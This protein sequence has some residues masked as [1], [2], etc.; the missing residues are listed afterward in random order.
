MINV[1][2][3]VALVLLGIVL[4][5]VV[6]LLTRR[7]VLDVAPLEIRLDALGKDQER[8]ERTV[9]DEISRGREEAAQHAKNLREEVGTGLRSANDSLV[10][11]LKDIS[12][13]QQ[14]QLSAFGAE[15]ADMKETS[16]TN[17]GHL[18]DDIASGF[19]E[20]NEAALRQMT[21][22][23]N[24][25]RG[26][27]TAMTSTLE[28]RLK[29]L[30]DDH[31]GRVDKISAEITGNAKQAREETVGTLLGFN[32][33][34]VRSIG[35][36]GAAQERELKELAV[37]FQSLIVSNE[38]KLDAIRG[39]VEEKLGLIQTDNA[40]RLDEMRRT[41][42]EKLQATLERRL[43]ES[44]RLV[45]E[46]LEQ[47]HRGL[48][49]MQTLA[50][51]VGDLKRVLTNVKARGSWGEVQLGNL[52]DEILAPEQF[53]KNVATKAS[54]GE[55]VDYAIK[56]PRTG[57]DDEYVWLP[58][59]AKFPVEDYQRLVDAAD[60]A[61]AAGVDL[62]AKQ[63]EMRIRACAQNIC[64][65]Y[66]NPPNTTDFGIM[67]LPTEGLYAEAVRRV[68]L[69]EALQREYRVV[70]AGPTTLAALLNSLQMGFR[71]LAI[72]KRSSEVWS[73]LGAVKTEFG[74]FGDVLTS[75]QKKLAEASATIDKAGVRTRAIRR[76][77]REVEELP[78]ADAQAALGTTDAAEVD[79]EPEEDLGVR[80]E[81]SDQNG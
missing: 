53:G 67:F 14:K 10:R 24:F 54:T 40:R 42:D 39:I 47:V 78:P 4:V 56:L 46:R 77:L 65:K 17:A 66:L 8:I 7:Q 44:F 52:L 70:V 60:K 12:D 68:G 76:K 15:V 37:Q 29:L 36:M 75:V 74:K 57:G 9:R 31:A 28:G 5:L 34:V 21:E 55:R 33:S 79:A 64:E 19:R 50:H 81:G 48:G 20:A 16:H 23:G 80:S 11:S 6:R 62:A 3:A 69:I 41:V 59:D 2:I 26:E 38:R 45:G 73:I 13:T 63:L 51:G 35:E 43:G 32:D 61:D 22:V 58:I 49:E 27:L 18:R 1:F 25:L 71:T 72:Q 30:Q